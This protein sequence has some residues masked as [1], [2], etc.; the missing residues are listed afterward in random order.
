[1]DHRAQAILYT[2][3]LSDRHR[4]PVDSG[5]LYYMK[6]GHMVGV[7]ALVHEKRALVMRR[8]EVARYLSLS[9]TTGGLK[10]PGKGSF[11]VFHSA[12]YT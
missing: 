4:H 1:V 5:L 2:L 9:R 7:P 12:Q 3:L 11:C 10:M 8:N 6:S